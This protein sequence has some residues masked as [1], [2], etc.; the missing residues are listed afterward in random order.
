[1]DI[2]VGVD[3]NIN[4]DQHIDMNMNRGQ[5]GKKIECRIEYKLRKMYSKIW[6]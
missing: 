5:N 4:I 6:K 3:M 2:E 1:M